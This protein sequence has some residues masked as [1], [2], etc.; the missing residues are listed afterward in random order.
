MGARDSIRTALLLLSI[1]ALSQSL[2]PP[3]ISSLDEAEF[4]ASGGELIAEELDWT[5][6]ES[7]PKESLSFTQGLEIHDG[8]LYESGGLYG[9]SSLR[10]FSLGSGTPIE[11]V[12]ISSD[13]FAEGLTIYGDEIIVLTWKSGRV[14][15][16]SFGLEQVNESLIFGEGWGICSMNN[17]LATSDGS[18]RITFRNPDDLVQVSNIEVTING[19]S[20]DQINEL[21]CLGDKIYANRWYDNRIFEIDMITGIV[22]SVLDFSSLADDYG[23]D[24][25]GHVLNGIAFDPSSGD[26]WITGKNWT[27]FHRI[28]IID[29]N[30]HVSTFDGRFLIVFLVSSSLLLPL[31]GS[32]FFNI[33]EPKGIQA[34]PHVGRNRGAPHG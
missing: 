30:Q 14:L 1:I 18:S 10:V 34:A 15:R 20:L 23:S 31:F 16:Y 4:H 21:E 33:R 3:M 9:H 8:L 6:V 27:D 2:N 29:N 32:V 17:Q 24:A 25:N 11:T 28:S 26:F 7:V 13:L 22:T 5:L 19:E 12:N